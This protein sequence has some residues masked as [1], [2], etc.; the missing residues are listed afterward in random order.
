[1]QICFH[2]L[3]VAHQGAFAD[4]PITVCATIVDGAVPVDVEKSQPLTETVPFTAR[5]EK[6][7]GVNPWYAVCAVVSIVMGE[8]AVQPEGVQ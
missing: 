6:L 4:R 1:M 7:L 2:S 5:P 3:S 8:A